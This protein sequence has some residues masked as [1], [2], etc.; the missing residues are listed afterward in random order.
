MSLERKVPAVCLV[1]GGVPVRR[2]RRYVEAVES[3]REID[4]K[5]WFLQ[6]DRD[7]SHGIRKLGL[8]Q[9]YKNAYNIQ[10]LKHPTQSPDCNPIEGIWAILKQRIRD[11][12]FD[13]EDNIK[14]ALQEE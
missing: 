13:T 12:I 14:E 8:A 11:R 6:E 3:I 1:T 7:P 5:P 9:E 10:N 4:D 2:D